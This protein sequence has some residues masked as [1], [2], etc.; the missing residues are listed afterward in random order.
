MSFIY[1]KKSDLIEQRSAGLIHIIMLLLQN[2]LI[3]LL[4]P[5]HLSLL[6]FLLFNYVLYTPA[7]I[8]CLP[9]ECAM[10]FPRPYPVY[11]S[12]YTCLSPRPWRPP[13]P[14]PVVQTSSG[15]LAIGRSSSLSPGPVCGSYCFPG[16]SP[17]SIAEVPYPGPGHRVPGS[18]VALTALVSLINTPVRVTPKLFFIP[19][20]IFGTVIRITND[21][22]TY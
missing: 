17:S 8:L 4:F 5:L 3:S 10:G 22:G 16:S 1:I 14:P 18:F 12:H 19:W 21:D 2:F 13:W 6:F 20:S 11:I 9:P 15:P 7:L